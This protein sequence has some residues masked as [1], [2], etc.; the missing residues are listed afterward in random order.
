MLLLEGNLKEEEQEIDIEKYAKGIY[1]LKVVGKDVT[2]IRK[3]IKE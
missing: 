3:I 1:I 2:Q